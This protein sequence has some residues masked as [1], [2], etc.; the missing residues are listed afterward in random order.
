MIPGAAWRELPGN[1]HLIYAGDSGA[2]VEEVERFVV[3]LAAAGAIRHQWRTVVSVYAPGPHARAA[4]AALLLRLLGE[5]GGLERGSTLEH[6]RAAFSGPVRALR[7]ARAVTLA[8]RRLGVPVGVGVAAGACAAAGGVPTGPAARVAD[9]LASR[10]GGY[11]VRLTEQVR[12]LAAGA[13]LDFESR[14]EYASPA[15]GSPVAA[16]ALP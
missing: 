16:L 14:G 1:D 3:G 10:A 6:L 9:E 12:A 8:A 13:D 2:V 4:G 5:H 15:A 7:F 11:E